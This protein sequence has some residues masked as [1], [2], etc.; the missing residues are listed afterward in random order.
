MNL[1]TC[2][3]FKTAFQSFGAPA[4]KCLKNVAGIKVPN[5]QI[6]TNINEV[7]EVKH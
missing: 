2:E 4:P 5:K 7:D 6:F 3:M 1:F